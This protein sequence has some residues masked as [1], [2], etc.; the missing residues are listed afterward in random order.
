VRV[1]RPAILDEK[2]GRTAPAAFAADEMLQRAAS[3]GDVHEHRVLEKF[4]AE[5]GTYSPGNPGGVYEGGSGGHH[6][7]R[8]PDGEA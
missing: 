6:G 7:P 3:L 1:P 8:H 5:L 4:T 2:L